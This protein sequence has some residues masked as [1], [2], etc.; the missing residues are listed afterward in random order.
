MAERV[1]KV[2]TGERGES[3]EATYPNPVSNSAGVNHIEPAMEILYT[4]GKK[5]REGQRVYRV[6]NLRCGGLAGTA[7][8]ETEGESRRAG[9]G[10]GNTRKGSKNNDV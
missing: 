4:Q 7:L 6:V 3:G 2:A 8:R 5:S 10:E 1:D 9:D